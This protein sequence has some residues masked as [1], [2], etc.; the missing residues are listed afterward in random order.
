MTTL[1]SR[2][3]ILVFLFCAL[4][5]GCS[6]G[7]GGGTGTDT[8]PPAG[9]P[10]SSTPP[11]SS[12]PPPPGNIPAER[13]VLNVVAPTAWTQ[14]SPEFFGGCTFEGLREI[15]YG[16]DGKWRTKTYLNSFPGWECNPG[17]FGGDPAPGVAKRCEVSNVMLTGTISA[18]RVCHSGGMCPAIDLTA[19]PMGLDGAGEM[20]VRPTNE[21]APDS[22]DGTGNFRTVCGFSHMAF[23]DPIVYPGQ[24]GVSH[25]HAFFGNV[26]ANAYST[27]QSLANSGNSTCLGGIA[28]RSAYWVPALINTASK[29]PLVPGASIWYYKTGYGGVTA[30]SVKPMPAGLRMIAG[31]MM[32]TGAQS[33]AHWS[34]HESGTLRGATIP[35]CPVGEHVAMTIQFPQCWDGA[36]LDSTDHKSHMAY[37][38]GRGCPASHPVALPEITLNVHYLVRAA[39]EALDWK[40]SSDRLTL[41]AGYSAH[42]DWFDGWNPDI[43]NAW[44]ANCNQKAKDCHAHLVGDGRE[45][46]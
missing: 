46:Y 30:A 20:R 33:M 24:P 31:D 7:G 27:A 3:P 10:A 25:L 19:I 12:N 32:A 1:K 35:N 17:N 29:K 44:V 4:I 37:P 15:R 40:L 41:P 13:A 36:N 8:P 34:C 26:G 42:A 38:T 6:G 22:S 11:P 16:T 23:D 21:V 28:N 5:V 39:N 2:F 45:L 18:P 9:P 43:R 14:C